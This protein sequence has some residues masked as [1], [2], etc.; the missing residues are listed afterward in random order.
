MTFALRPALP[1]RIAAARTRIAR[2]RRP[3]K[4]EI[5]CPRNRPARQN[6]NQCAGATPYR[7]EALKKREEGRLRPAKSSLGCRGEPALESAHIRRAS[8]SK[9]MAEST[10]PDTGSSRQTPQVPAESW[11]SR[12][13]RSVPAARRRR[14]KR[15]PSTR[16]KKYAR[17]FADAGVQE[18]RPSKRTAA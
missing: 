14:R 6:Q 18:S 2:A 11:C 3:A 1:P 10:I 12:V 9:G 15:S 7:V 4:S 8:E 17:N 16:R 13:A 5:L